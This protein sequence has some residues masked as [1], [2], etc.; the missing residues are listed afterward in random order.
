MDTNDDTI[1]DNENIKMSSI[2]EFFL[3]FS[4]IITSMYTEWICFV[5][6]MINVLWN[7]H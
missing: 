7:D 2:Y 6:D 4:A 1:K 5:I 3:Q